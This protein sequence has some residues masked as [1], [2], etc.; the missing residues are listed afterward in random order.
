MTTAATG[1]GGKFRRGLW[2]SLANTVISRAATFG[3]GVV[4][5]RILSPAEF[6]MY[7]TALVMQMLLLVINDLG[8]GAALIRRSD[9]VERMLPTAWTMSVGGGAVCAVV[10]FSVSGPMAALLGSPGATGILQLMSLNILTN[11]F[12][13]VPASLLKRDFEQGKRLV[14][15]LVGLVVNLGLT[16]SLALAGAGPWSLA[17]GHVTAGSLVCVLLMATTHRWP[18]FGYDREYAGEVAR[19]G[20]AMAGSSVLLICLQSAPQAVTGRLLGAGAIGYF[21]I[22]NNVA[23]WPVQIISTTLERVALATFSRAK[24]DGRALGRT[25]AAVIGLVAGAV[26]I[27]GTSLA[28]LAS[29]IIAVVYGHAWLPAASML[30]GLALAN[31]ARVTAELV[32]NLLVATDSMLSSIL[33]QAA[34]LVVLV[35]VSAL[36]AHWYGFEGIGWAQAIVGFL[37]AVPVN[38]WCARKAGVGAGLLLRGLRVPA[39]VAALL[40]V[41]LLGLRAVTT[42]DVLIVLVGGTISAVALLGA[43]VLMKD[44]LTFEV[45]EPAEVPPVSLSPAAGEVRAE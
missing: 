2:L 4:L 14:A 45:P 1:L 6:G 19:I 10:A 42:N 30:A 11:G 38:L 32:F 35:P 15:D 28:L 36:G 43:Y 33:P 9:M 41:V 25:A 39:V 8:V 22:A 17:I 26:L 27:A 29:P 18:K 31:V 24:E 34:W 20:A 44:A 3:L 16:L 21:F 23:N 5:A 7:A 40:A 13:S 12:A 37:W